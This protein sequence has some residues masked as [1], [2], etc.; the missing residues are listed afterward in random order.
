MIQ[1]T[2]IK[3]NIEVDNDIGVNIIHVSE[4][5]NQEEAEKVCDEIDDLNKQ[6][7]INHNLFIIPMGWVSTISAREYLRSELK[8]TD[9][10][11]V[12]K[13][14]L[15]RALLENEEGFED[16]EIHV[17]ETRSEALEKISDGQT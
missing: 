8:T 6:Y 3:S 14:P 9:N 7:N 10:Y 17:C 12:I 15:Q 4:I 13:S 1:I 2:K 16:G 5:F 11:F